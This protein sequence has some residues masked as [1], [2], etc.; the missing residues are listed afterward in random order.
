[1]QLSFSFIILSIGCPLQQLCRGKDQKIVKYVG[2]KVRRF[3]PRRRPIY[4]CSSLSARLFSEL[5]CYSSL[6]SWIPYTDDKG[7]ITSCGS[8]QTYNA[9]KEFANKKVVLFAVPGQSTPRSHSDLRY[10]TCFLFVG[11]FTPGCSVRHLP[12]YI[13]NLSKFKSKGVDLIIVIAFNDAWYVFCS[14]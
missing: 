5:N 14:L 2:P 10:L 4:V 6:V 3:L 12:P 1:M 11:A 9:S 7:D 13:E 8:P